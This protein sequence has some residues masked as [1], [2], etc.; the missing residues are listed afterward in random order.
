MLDARDE[1]QGGVVVTPRKPRETRKARLRRSYA[2][3]GQRRRLEV[4]G[5]AFELGIDIGRE[6]VFFLF[7]FL[8]FL[9]PSFLVG[10][11]GSM[12]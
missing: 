6:K 12:G 3:T 5:W 10:V 8:F 7:H 11:N 2:S 4:R 9:D 1:Q